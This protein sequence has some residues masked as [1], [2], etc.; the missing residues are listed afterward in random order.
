MK[1]RTRR[2]FLQGSLVLAGL[3]MLG[4]CG[5]VPSATPTPAKVPRIGWLGDDSRGD[6]LKAFRQGLGELGYVEGQTIVIEVRHHEGRL[7]RLPELAAELVRLEVDVIVTA[8][9]NPGSGLLG[10]RPAGSRS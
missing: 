9:G 5:V 2:R 7:E 4:G 3:G 10:R 8:S 6:S 1:H